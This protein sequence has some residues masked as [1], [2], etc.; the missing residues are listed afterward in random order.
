MERNKEIP[1][2]V[3]SVELSESAKDMGGYVR[4]VEAVVSL[5]VFVLRDH[6]PS[7]LARVSWLQS[8]P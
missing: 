4:P 7:S 2:L 8:K 5:V 6:I 1:C 3:S